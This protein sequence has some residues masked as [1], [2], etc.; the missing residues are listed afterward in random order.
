M[1]LNTAFRVLGDAQS[2]QDVHQEVFLAIWQRWANLD[3]KVSW[4]GYLYRTTVRKAIDMIRK[5]KPW[6][7]SLEGLERSPQA[8]NQRPHQI[9]VAQELQERLRGCIAQLPERQA[10]VFVL[11]K[12]EGHKHAEI[13]ACLDCSEG[14]VRVHLHRALQR[15][16]ELMRDYMEVGADS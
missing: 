4:P 14:T 11:S 7:D 5:D 9:L 6:P 10:H 8:P 15:L 16:S 2:A 13:A 3:R 1:V 12:L